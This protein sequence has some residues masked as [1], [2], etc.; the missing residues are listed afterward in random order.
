MTTAEQ[1]A[2]MTDRIVTEAL[3]AVRW[4]AMEDE[5]RVRLPE[6]CDEAAEAARWTRLRIAFMEELARDVR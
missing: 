5:V 1:M 4:Q 2:A 6:L 3:D